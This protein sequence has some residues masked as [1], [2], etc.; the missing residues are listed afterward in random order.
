MMAIKCTWAPFLLIFMGINYGLFAQEAKPADA[1]QTGAT[2]LENNIQ[3]GGDESPP[4]N[5]LVPRSARRTAAYWIAL[6][7]RELKDNNLDHAMEAYEKA[8]ESDP[9]NKSASIGL[10]TI[11][12]RIK[13]YAPALE[14]IEPL[15]DKYPDDYQIKNNLAW[16]YA[17]A[18]DFSVRSGSKAVATAQA[19]LLL[20][21]DDYH[22]WS[23]LSEAYYVSGEYEKARRAIDECLRLAT[24]HGASQGEIR[25]YQMQYAKCVKA[26]EAMS[27]IE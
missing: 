5:K 10:A 19:A 25:G 20:A 27:L 12:L 13:E 9:E 15:V 7:N 2:A 21:P 17:T 6:G 1:A 18:D 8:L 16:V 23:T 14:I 3:S 11:L 24:Q 22:V 4:E 26:D